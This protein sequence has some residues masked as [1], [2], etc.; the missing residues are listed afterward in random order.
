[1]LAACLLLVV[2]GSSSARADDD[3]DKHEDDWL[4]GEVEIGFVQQFKTD[5]DNSGEFETTGGFG[6]AQFV[7]RLSDTV[8]IRAVSSYYGLDYGFDDAPTIAGSA[9]KP[10]N[11]VHVARLNP[12]VE[13]QINDRWRVF[14]GPLFEASFENGADLRDGFKPGGLLG[15]KVEV[16]PAL[17]VGFGILGVAELEDHAYIQP[18]LLLDW[19]AGDRVTVHAESWTTRGARIEVVYQVNDQFEVTTSLRYRRERFRLK[20]RIV[21]IGPPE[22]PRTGSEGIGEDRAV[23]PALRLSYLP[24]AQF[25][26]DTLGRPRLDLEVGVALAGDLRMESDTGGQIQ[27]MSYDPAPVLKLAIT[28]PL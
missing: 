8:R 28:V 22:I 2:G 21:D 27:T 26:R 6:R 5:L 19:K 20:E 18:L 3:K 9:F 16:S 23:I 12:L 4:E 7:M 17:T 1:L 15:A 10:W 13:V 25:I 14:G 11:T 24:D